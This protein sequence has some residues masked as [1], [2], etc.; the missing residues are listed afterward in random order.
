MSKQTHKEQRQTSSCV[1]PET[2]KKKKRKSEN[3]RDEATAIYKLRMEKN[4]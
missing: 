2:E 3:K 1:A 4:N